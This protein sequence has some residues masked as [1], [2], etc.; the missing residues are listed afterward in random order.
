MDT[1]G[2]VAAIVSIA[3]IESSSSFSVCFLVGQLVQCVFHQRFVPST[4]LNVLALK[5]VQLFIGKG[6]MLK[7]WY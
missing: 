7:F 5:K 3:P 4:A 6:E 1:N 2:S